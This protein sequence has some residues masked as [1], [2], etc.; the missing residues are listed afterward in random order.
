MD[1]NISKF[2]IESKL[3]LEAS[4]F[5]VSTSIVFFRDALWRQMHSVVFRGPFFVLNLASIE[6]SWPTVCWQQCLNTMQSFLLT[7]LTGSPQ[8]SFAATTCWQNR[9]EL[10]LCDQKHFQAKPARMASLH[11]LLMGWFLFEQCFLCADYRHAC[12]TGRPLNELQ[13]DFS[14]AQTLAPAK[15]QHQPKAAVG[16]TTWEQSLPVQGSTKSN[17]LQASTLLPIGFQASRL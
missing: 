3:S 1:F 17:F 6:A 13:T 5:S 15:L 7:K 8:S 2:G 14:Q 16:G 10:R 9:L 11:P 4:S 12:W